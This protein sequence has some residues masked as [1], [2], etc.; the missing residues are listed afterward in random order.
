M[1]THRTLPLAALLSLMAP[2][3]AQDSQPTSQPSHSAWIADYD[4]ALV[5]A[6]ETGKDLLV[7]FTGSDWCHWC[8]RLDGEVF[9]HE[10]FLGPAQEKFVLCSLD[11]PRSPAIAKTVPNPQ[12][13]QELQAK[14]TVQGFPTI[15]LIDAEDEALLGRT[16]Y[17]PG[18]PTAY[19]T[20]LDAMLTTAKQSIA[21]VENLLEAFDKSSEPVAVL[22]QASSR[23]AEMTGE[24]PGVKKLGTLVRKVLD[25]GAESHAELRKQAVLGLL[26][27]DQADPAIAKMGEAMDPENAAGILEQVIVFEFRKVDDETSA[28]AAVRR[29]EVLEP[30]PIID[31]DT[32]RLIFMNAARLAGMPQIAADAELAKKYAKKALGLGIDDPRAKAMLEQIA[33]KQ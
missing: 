32:G 4:E 17:Q 20:H 13:N 22:R 25:L 29:A 8:I 10:E 18:G 28:L 24:T 30:L 16:G 26:K 5:I 21:D 12:R 9:S 33:G 11:F 1:T 6:R 19:M 3:I 31:A 14:Y 7:D 27:S 23:L 15:L 2:A